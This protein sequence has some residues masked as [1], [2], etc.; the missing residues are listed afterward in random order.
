MNGSNG[1]ANIAQQPI[2]GGYDQDVANAIIKLVSRRSLFV[3]DIVDALRKDD[4]P[5]ISGFADCGRDTI[6]VL[7]MEGRVRKESTGKIGRIG[8]PWYLWFLPSR[9]EVAISA[10]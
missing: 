5:R 1:A 9:K 3:S 6:E 8:R 10:R 7:V 4:D 2:V